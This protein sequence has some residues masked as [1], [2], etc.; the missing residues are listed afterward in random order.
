MKN[1]DYNLAIAP[2][3]YPGKRYRGRYCP[4]HHLV[5]WKET[6]DVPANDEV[7]HHI[8]GDRRN[9]DFDNLEKMTRS[10]HT[11]RHNERGTTMAVMECPEC[12]EVFERERRKTHLVDDRR[13]ATFCSR[14]CAGKFS[15]RNVTADPTVVDVYR[16]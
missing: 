3:G 2:D 16:A 11:A 4:E 5:W 6:G 12:G 14:S 15:Q 7:I 1:G 8:D 10:E 9:N 13:D